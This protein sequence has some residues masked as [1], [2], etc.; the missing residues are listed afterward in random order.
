MNVTQLN[1]LND[2]CSKLK[3]RTGNGIVIQILI[4]DIN[5]I[6]VN[7]IIND[8]R[9][10]DFCCQEHFILNN[11]PVSLFNDFEI[12][13]NSNECKDIIKYCQNIGNQIHSVFINE[14][15][16]EITFCK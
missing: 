11:F 14:E 10:N 12:I 13:K 5:D 2:L 3:S 8:I 9:I 15:K 7:Y 16:V 1:E 6:E 4:Y